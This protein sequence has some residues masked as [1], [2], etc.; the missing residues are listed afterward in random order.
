MVSPAPALLEP[1]FKPGR[2][3]TLRPFRCTPLLD[4]QTPPFQCEVST[5]AI[6]I[7][8]RE[9]TADAPMKTACRRAFV[10]AS[11]TGSRDRGIVMRC[12]IVAVRMV[13]PADITLLLAEHA[14][15]TLS[16]AFSL[17]AGGEKNAAQYQ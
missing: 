5:F 15:P 3:T 13:L 2:R 11:K 9:S 8:R 1:E 16:F 7:P 14:P 6:T 17:A 4:D 10:S 12:R